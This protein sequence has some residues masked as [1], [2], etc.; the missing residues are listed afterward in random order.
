MWQDGMHLTESFFLAAGGAAGS[1]VQRTATRVI[2]GQP[3]Y[4]VYLKQI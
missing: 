2:Q 4:V 1:V 3:P